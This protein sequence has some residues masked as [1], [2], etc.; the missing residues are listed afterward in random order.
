MH[1]FTAIG[2][3]I[4]LIA[5][6]SAA[7]NADQHPL[8]QHSPSAKMSKSLNVFKKPLA[9]HSTQPMT[10]F[11]RTG[12]CEVPAGDYGIHAVAAE[13]TD[14]FLDFTARQG[15]DLRPIPGMKAGC[16]WCLCATRWREAF[17][18]RKNEAAGDKIV[19]KIFLHATNEKALG[20]MSLEE[21]K[22]FAADD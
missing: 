20:K 1:L 14:E 17:D 22:M 6:V 4:A 19:P 11:T 10:G 12:Y 13:V 7:H 15:N 21:L 5:T 16:K 18:A 2:I 3:L 8:H 9:L